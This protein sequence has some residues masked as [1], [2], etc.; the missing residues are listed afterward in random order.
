MGFQEIGL[1]VALEQELQ[2]I[3]KSKGISLSAT[4]GASMFKEM[5]QQLAATH[6]VVVLIDEYDA[7]I[8]NYLGK[9][10]QQAYEN[11]E[12]LKGFYTVLKDMDPYL[13]LVFITGVSKFSKVGI[14][15]GLNNLTDLTMHPQYA[16]MLGYT[17]EELE[18]NFVEELADCAQ[19]LQLTHEQLLDKLRWWYNGCRFHANASTVYNP[20]SL[21]TFFSLKE[22]KNFWFETGTPSFL[23]NLLKQEGLYDFRL[24]PQ[25][26]QSFDT[27]DLE[28]L[29][30]YG[31]LYQTAYLTIKSRNAFGLYELD[32]PNHEVEHAMNGY[33]LK[34]FGGMRKGNALPL[35]F[36]LETLLQQQKLEEVML[37][38]QGMFKTIPYSP[39]E[40]YPEKFFHAAI[41]VLFTYMGV[42]VHSE[43]CTSDGRVDAV[44]ET[45]SQIYIFEFKLDESAETALAQIRDKK[46]YQA[47][48]LKAKPLVGIGV[49]VSSATKNID[50]WQMEELKK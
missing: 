48:W 12:L 35:I 38:L 16:T 4:G 44:V 34:A 42:T 45:D 15:S 18:E 43:V 26:E 21:N 41:H 31:L 3:A 37:A 11:R 6:K 17:Q 8:V 32:Y 46:H 5:I 28:D 13:E 49:N 47:F 14:F 30:I 10:I 23:I 29:N 7:P 36:K 39:H 27:F 25:P 50:G 24:E 33:L 19:K 1:K 2:M 20:V 40:K 22:F 9:D